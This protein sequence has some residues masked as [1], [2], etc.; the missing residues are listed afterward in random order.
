MMGTSAMNAV[1]V[2]LVIK[3][4]P[5]NNLMTERRKLFL[6]LMQSVARKASKYFRSQ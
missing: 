3:R 4:I 6:D 1:V 5:L 2:L